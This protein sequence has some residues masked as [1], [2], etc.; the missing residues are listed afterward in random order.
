LKNPWFKFEISVGTI[1][2]LATMLTLAAA[3]YSK[4]D[5]RLSATEKAVEVNRLESIHQSEVMSSVV[6]Q[7]TRLMTIMEERKGRF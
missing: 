1:L 4:F 6:N 7:Q 2:Q 3:A 5:A